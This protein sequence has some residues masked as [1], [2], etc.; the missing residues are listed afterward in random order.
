LKSRFE[1]ASTAPKPNDTALQLQT[2]LYLQVR[3]FPQLLEIATSA[4][5]SDQDRLTRLI[6]I[7]K[8]TG[9]KKSKHTENSTKLRSLLIEWGYVPPS[10][11]P[12]AEVTRALV[13]SIAQMNNDRQKRLTPMQQQ[14]YLAQSPQMNDQ[15]DA[16]ASGQ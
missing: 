15:T 10:A 6:Q 9:D 7:T 4:A 5:G 11:T 16:H 3:G 14:L 1:E 12:S 2:Q 8:D 13:P